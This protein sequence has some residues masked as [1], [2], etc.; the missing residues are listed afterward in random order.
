MPSDLSLE[1]PDLLRLYRVFKTKNIGDMEQLEPITFFS[2]DTFIRQKDVIRYEAQIKD[3]LSH[4]VAAPDALD[5]SSPLQQVVQE[6]Q[7]PIIKQTPKA[8]LNSPPSYPA[9][10]SGLIHL[11]SAMRA[12]DGLVSLHIDTLFT[13]CLVMTY[14]LART[15]V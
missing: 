12:T 4:L 2:R 15:S 13:W 11:L 6:V 8:Q 3:T 9:F 5:P 14:C 7:D 1:A 10:L